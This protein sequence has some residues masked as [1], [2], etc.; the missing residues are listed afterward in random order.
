[1]HVE[2][3]LARLEHEGAAPRLRRESNS[4][5][6][7]PIRKFGSRIIAI[8]LHFQSQHRFDRSEVDLSSQTRNSRPF[9]AALRPFP[10]LFFSYKFAQDGG[11][12]SRVHGVA[13]GEQSVHRVRRRRIAISCPDKVDHG[14][15]Q[16]LVFANGL[17][18]KR[19][20]NSNSL[21]KLCPLALHGVNFL[22]KRFEFFSSALKRPLI[23]G[24]H[25]G[26]SNSQQYWRVQ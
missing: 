24:F 16:S 10:E 1:L 11:H 18:Q 26:P 22:I 13:S 25:V 15:G 14:I 23:F 19:L 7:G 4:V 12:T 5:R 8:R 9:V 3:S 20:K 6:R 21:P 17:S 2:S